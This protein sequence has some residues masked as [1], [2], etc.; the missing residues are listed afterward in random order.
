MTELTPDSA[1][2]VLS[3]LHHRLDVHFHRLREARAALDAEAPVFALEHGLLPIDLD[4]LKAAVR[5]AVAAG[6]GQQFWRQ[7]WLPFVVYAAES[8]YDYVGTE[9][10]QSFEQTTPDWDLY[11]NRDRIR[12]WFRRFNREYGGAVPK[13]AFARNFP[14][15]AWPITHALLPVY[16]QRYLAQLLY[17][18]R[19]GF[20]AELL[21]QPEEF[22]KRLAARA[23][24]YTE[25]FRIFCENPAMLGQVATALLSGEGEA[26]PYLLRS[27]LLRLIDGLEQQ[28]EAKFWLQGARRAATQVRT[29]GFQANKPRLP[30]GPARDQIPNPTDPRLVLRAGENG[31]RVF[32]ELPDLS[33]LSR[34][35]PHVYEELR[36]K[37][38]RV[39]GADKTVLAGGRLTTLGQEVRLTRWPNPEVPFIQLEDGE[40][41]VNALLRDQVE[42]GRGPIWLFKRRDPGTAVEVKSKLVRPGN[43]Y[44]VVHRRAW[45]ISDV[46]WVEKRALDATEAELVRLDIPDRLDDRET[47][48]L[49]TAG[50]TVVTDVYIR[51]VGIA[52]S[53]WDGEG[54]IEWLAGEPGL[55]GIH[56]QQMPAGYTLSLNGEHYNQT[57]PEGEDEL[58][59]SLDGLPIGEH[60]LRVE[61]IGANE[62]TIANGA[63]QVTVRDPQVHSDTAGAGEGIRLLASPARP[64][65]SELWEPEA[66][67][68]AGPEGLRVAITTTLHS[69]DR[70]ELDRISL[71]IALPLVGGNWARVA[72]R[73]RGDDRFLRNFDQAESIQLTVSH[74]GVGYATLRADRGF[75]PLRWQLFRARE[76]NRAHLI[77]RTDSGS[78]RIEMYT[79]EQ[80]LIAVPCDP[81][82]DVVA[83]PTG[84]LL[85][86]VAGE[87]IDAEATVLLPTQPNHLLGV[88][89]ASEVP[90]RSRTPAEV[91][92]LAVAYQR[93]ADADLP[94]DVF[95][96]H[97]RDTV[98]EAI[99][100]A[101]VSTV[102][103]GRWASVERRLA[104]ASDPLD[105]I[106]DMRQTI[107]D[108]GD[109][110]RLAQTIGMNLHAWH[111]PAALL[112]GFAEAIASTLRSIGVTGH[113]S[114]PRFLL[115][116]AGCPGQTLRWPVA[117][118][119]FLLQQVLQHPVLLRAARF[120][121]LGTELFNDSGDEMGE[122]G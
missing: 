44:Y 82:T 87:G 111:H 101:L 22:G 25:R 17:E 86:A 3:Q 63:L 34:R 81:K 23:W 89:I 33:S 93:W 92:K 57:W 97:Q 91:T 8:G 9:F 90:A 14:I 122:S 104:R 4:T 24:A 45:S 7:S 65:M 60:Q 75:Q 84:G 51:P 39:E 37:R 48:A 42:V 56:V 74:A 108:N 31:W 112:T 5:R 41:A 120:A 62:Q 54:S 99:T 15:I 105:L 79:V 53:A 13:G 29:H 64:T 88:R 35:L 50:L 96:Q 12:T 94:G 77:D 69:D 46:A 83:P 20:T 73:I 85:R 47:S 26:S 116:L 19:M 38:A 36:A 76:C 68:L 109:E 16:L 55:V 100:R 70:R 103:V 28:R 40:I 71:Q 119:G 2:D 21:Q 58:F 18:F 6:F 27:T 43:T 117:E 1:L 61:L 66:I 52:A 110:R 95:A 121:V 113:D 72:K 49:V 59:L 32:A 98:L 107:G 78:S 67:M 30:G 114:A 102:C 118:R 115:T 80:P 11:G 10:W 106:D